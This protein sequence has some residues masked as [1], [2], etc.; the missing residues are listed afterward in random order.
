MLV[1]AFFSRETSFKERESE[2]KSPIL[3]Y[4]SLWNQ[5]TIFCVANN[6]EY[7]TLCILRGGTLVRR[8]FPFEMKENQR[9][10]K[11][12]SVAEAMIVRSGTTASTVHLLGLS[13]FALVT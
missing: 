12:T 3:K 2:G 6:V 7:F 5:K 4:S 8:M 1:H 10:G 11:L 13:P 9:D